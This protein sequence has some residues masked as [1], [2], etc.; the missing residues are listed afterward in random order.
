MEVLTAKMT[1]DEFFEVELP[2][3]ASYSYELL[4]G[5]LVR[6]NAPSGEHQLVQSELFGNL[7]IFISQKNL[8]KLFSA[9][10]SV[11]LSEFD[12]PQPDILFLKKENM[13]RYDPDWGIKGAPDMVVEIVSPSSFKN[14]RFDKKQL[15]ETHG[16]SE[17]WL[18]D[19]TYKSIEVFT[20]K[21]G[22]YHLHAFGVG[23]EK[24]T[25]TILEGLELELS[26][27]FGPQ[28]K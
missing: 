2:D 11:V 7:Y 8:G 18:V 12:A 10:T 27:I 14:D 24:I 3:E 21:N 26:K 1:V 19:P 15:Y 13:H 23:D 25:S 6:R 17:Y 4:N 5:Q 22:Q 16:V 9:P 20:L 28:N